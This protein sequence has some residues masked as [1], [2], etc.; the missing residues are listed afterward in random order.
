M[1]APEKVVAG[2]A[3]TSTSADFKRNR[4]REWRVG[5]ACAWPNHVPAFYIVVPFL[6]PP[7][8]W[9]GEW[10]CNWN[11]ETSRTLL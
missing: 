9:K 1:P 6:L 8:T 5:A 10:A 2:Q 11:L 3:A 4:C 7:C